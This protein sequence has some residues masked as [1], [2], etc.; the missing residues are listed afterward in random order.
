MSVPKVNLPSNSAQ[1]AN[2]EEACSSPV[3]RAQN[4]HSPT[5]PSESS[6]VYEGFT[7]LKADPMSNQSATWTCVERNAMHLSQDEYLKMIQKRAKKRSVAQQYQNLSFHTMRAH[8]NQLVDEQRRNDPLVEWS[9]VYVKEHTK[10]FKARNARRGDYETL[11]M[12]VI[13]MGRHMKTQMYPR[14]QM[15]DI[16]DFGKFYRAESKHL[17]MWSHRVGQPPVPGNEKE[18]V[19]RPMPQAFNSQVAPARNALAGGRNQL[20]QPTQISAAINNGP[21]S[22]AFSA[23]ANSDL[24]HEQTSDSSAESNSD[25]DDA[26]IL[27][28]QSDETSATEDS[29]SADTETEYHKL[30][31]NKAYVRQTV[32]PYHRQSS[33]GPHSRRRPQSRSLDRRHGRNY[34][35]RHQFEVKSLGLRRAERSDS[36]ALGSGRRSRM[37]LR[38]DN[39]VRSRILDYREASIGHREKRLKRTFSEALQLERRQSMNDVSVVCRCTCRCAIKKR[40]AV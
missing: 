2:A 18:N 7:F 34:P 9:L 29:D 33:Q 40:E 8:I 35:L 14:T 38:D 28:D 21:P 10:L 19:L 4:V 6:P 31:R 22:P 16:V 37:Q 23:G 5:G 11:S 3:A 24:N 27:S 13:I 39:E 25:S 30:R 12:D 15:G 20:R 36:P 26:S 32:R 17:S 1:L